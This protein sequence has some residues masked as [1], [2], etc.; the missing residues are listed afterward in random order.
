M[1][2][3]PYIELLRMA[4]NDLS[5]STGITFPDFSTRAKS[6]GME[7]EVLH[8]FRDIYNPIFPQTQGLPEKN[9]INLEAYVKLLQYEELKHSLAESKQAR[10]EAKWAIWIAAGAVIVQ[11]AL[12]VIDKVA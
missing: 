4:K 12:W 8:L 1:T 10:T 3:D 5:N 11:I 2:T 7:T 9:F 6:L